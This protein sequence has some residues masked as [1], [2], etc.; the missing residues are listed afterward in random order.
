MIPAESE[1]GVGLEA[2]I[3]IQHRVNEIH[4]Q[5]FEHMKR[6]SG[7]VDECWRCGAAYPHLL[8]HICEDLKD[9]ESKCTESL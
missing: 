3:D 1:Y 5:M 9:E 4:N 6:S 2:L 8:I 7:A